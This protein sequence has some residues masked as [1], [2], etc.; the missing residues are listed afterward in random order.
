M[1][2]IKELYYDRQM[3]MLNIA[4]YLGVS[5]HSVVYFMRK[6]NLPRRTLSQ[7]N[8]INFNKE[9]LSFQ[10]VK[11]KSER[12]RVIEAMGTMLYWSEGN[13]S[14]KYKGVDFANS[15]PAMIK[16]FLKFIRERFKIT[17]KRLRVYLYCYSNQNTDDL[18]NYWSIQTGISPKQFTQPYIKISDPFSKRCMRYGLVH[19]RYCGS[20]LLSELKKLI[21]SYKSQYAPVV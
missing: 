12:E 11:P 13:K 10:Y 1:P 5:I 4:D 16:M 8:E 3:H 9:P 18:I 17:E 19:I 7:T 21:E 15:D 6:N 14:D 2:L 20:R